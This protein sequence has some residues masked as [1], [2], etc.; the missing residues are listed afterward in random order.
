MAIL[1]LRAPLVRVPEPPLVLLGAPLVV[2]GFA[3]A[4][5]G[6]NLFG[7]AGTTIKP[8]EKSSV[9]VTNGPFRFTRNPMYLSM[10]V[11]LLG[12]WLLLGTLG[13][14][15]IVP[16]FVVTIQR[17]F[18]LVEEAMLRSTFGAEYEAYLQR[19]RRWI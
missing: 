9:L 7:R 2:L 19:V 5:W 3:L 10:T 13:P 12:V 17:R 6:A 1:H 4:I 11:V 16:I 8:F 14:G 18:I 15:L